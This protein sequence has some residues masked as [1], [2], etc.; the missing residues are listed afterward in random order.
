VD[1][2]GA[3]AAAPPAFASLLASAADTGC[4]HRLHGLPLAARLLGAAPVVHR[5]ADGL[6]DL[7][8]GGLPGGLL[9]ALEDLRVGGAGERAGGGDE[10]GRGRGEEAGAEPSLH[11][12]FLQRR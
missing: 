11:G 6:V 7:A 12:D 3:C 9:H 1:A 5:A 2:A 4:V 10:D 8:L